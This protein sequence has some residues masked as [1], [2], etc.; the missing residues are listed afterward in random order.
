M[1][2]IVEYGL[3]LVFVGTYRNQKVADKKNRNVEI[4]QNNTDKS[5]SL[6][7]IEF[8]DYYSLTKV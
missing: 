3:A 4:S 6:I 5:V 8:A 7:A 1:S 2:V